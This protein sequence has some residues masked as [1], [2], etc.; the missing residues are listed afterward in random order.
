MDANQALH[1]LKTY[2]RLPVHGILAILWITGIGLTIRT[3]VAIYGLI[4]I[5]QFDWTFDL[6]LN[7]GLAF[8]LL[9]SAFVFTGTGIR[10]FESELRQRGVS[11]RARLLPFLPEQV[12]RFYLKRFPPGF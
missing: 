2:W 5:S 1:A 8:A 4:V 6:F 12:E 7:V 3:A 10:D 9:I 11:G